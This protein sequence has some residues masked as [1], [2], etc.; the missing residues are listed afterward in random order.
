M[1]P[2][3]GHNSLGAVRMA[4]DSCDGTGPQ[5]EDRG[6]PD[7]VWRS[8]D[9]PPR[10]GR[11]YTALHRGGHARWTAVGPGRRRLARRAA[12]HVRP[13]LRI[14]R[15]GAGRG[16]RSPRGS[17]DT[18]GAGSRRLFLRVTGTP[19]ARPLLDARVGGW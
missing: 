2:A 11:A 4:L 16:V 14:P 10:E 12:A 3:I 5:A 1:L 9:S 17:R 7:V 15:P 6:G 18:G 8:G 19:P 13:G